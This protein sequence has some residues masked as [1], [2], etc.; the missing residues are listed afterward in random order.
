MGG[1]Q[2]APSPTQVDPVAKKRKVL[3]EYFTPSPVYLSEVVCDYIGQH[4]LLLHLYSKQTIHSQGEIIKKYK[5]FKNS[6][7]GV[8]FSTKYAIGTLC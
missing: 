8:N 3:E 1:V 5:R 4:R 6:T 7:V 2:G